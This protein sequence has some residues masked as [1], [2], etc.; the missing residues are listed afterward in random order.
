MANSLLKIDNKIVHEWANAVLN[1]IHM[2]AITPI[3]TI[4]ITPNRTV[5]KGCANFTRIY[6]YTNTTAVT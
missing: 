4:A 6:G 3:H 1:P 2:V 5:V